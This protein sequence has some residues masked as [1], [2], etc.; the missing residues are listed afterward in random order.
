MPSDPPITSEAPQ[1]NAPAPEHYA[2]GSTVWPGLA[3]LAEETGELVQVLGKILGIGGRTDHWSGDLAAMLVDEMGDVLAALE[4]FAAENLTIAQ[5]RTL[6][7][8]HA[9]K[10]RLF[11]DWHDEQ[12]QPRPAPVDP[13][14]TTAD[15][16]V[17][18]PPTG[19]ELADHIDAGL[20]VE[21]WD[22]TEWK[23]SEVLSST[24]RTPH[25]AVLRQ[26]GWRCADRP[27]P[28]LPVREGHAPGTP[29]DAVARPA[30]VQS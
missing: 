22:L 5:R 12:T 3:K 17:G 16:D 2:L 30:D 11:Q 9:R 28:Y 15:L 13:M 18:A 29:R 14:T 8:R 25:V 23:P 1:A 27:G 6:A 21:R 19:T 10:L 4:L 24:F 26:H 20:A 7:D